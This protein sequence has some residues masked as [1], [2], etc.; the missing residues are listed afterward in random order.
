MTT[1]VGNCGETLA[2]LSANDNTL[3]QSFEI[4]SII[5]AHLH[6][7]QLYQN[8]KEQEKLLQVSILYKLGNSISLRAIA[9]NNHSSNFISH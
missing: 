7:K 1:V 6:M 2:V 3:Q 4:V 8:I 5:L 9:T